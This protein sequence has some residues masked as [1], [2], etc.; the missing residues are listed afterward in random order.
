MELELGDI[1]PWTAALSL[2]LLSLWIQYPKLSLLT[3]LSASLTQLCTCLLMWIFI[4]TEGS[5]H[6][7]R[8]LF[9]WENPFFRRVGNE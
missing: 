3:P 9:W 7:I 5:V 6:E 8:I 4:T 2:L 1:F